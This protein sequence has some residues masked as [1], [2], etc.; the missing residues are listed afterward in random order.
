MNMFTACLAQELSDRNIRVLAVDPGKV[1]TRFGPDDADTL[2]EDAA[3]Y[4]VALYED[5]T[6]TGA[7]VNTFGHRIPW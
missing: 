7:F 4:I 6:K 2:P 1:K 3:K 5:C